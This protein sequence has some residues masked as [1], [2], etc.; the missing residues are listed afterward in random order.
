MK[1]FTKSILALA[2]LLL[3][4]VQ[5]SAIDVNGVDVNQPII[6]GVE[7]ISFDTNFMA[8][9][10]GFTLGTIVHCKLGDSN[11]DIG[12]LQGITALTV[13]GKKENMSIV[14]GDFNLTV[15]LPAGFKTGPLDFNCYVTDYNKN[16]GR[17]SV[18]TIQIQ[19]TITTTEFTV[20]DAAGGA[21]CSIPNYA[22]SRI[23]ILDT[24]NNSYILF[25]DTIDINRNYNLDGN[26]QFTEQDGSTD[27]SLEVD[28][29]QLAQFANKRAHI[30][31]KALSFPSTPDLYYIPDGST[32]KQVCPT[33]LCYN[34]TYE[35]GTLEFDAE[36]FSLFAASQTS[37]RNIKQTIFAQPAAAMSITD[38]LFYIGGIS[39]TKLHAI[40]VLIAVIGLAVGWYAVSKK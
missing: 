12:R 5:V 17:S 23:K 36:H 29:T 33:D 10:A 1:N 15:K 8:N 6:S 11:V 28:T 18:D 14:T 34:V 38:S 30:V 9:V 2:I 31:M 7:C 25:Y 24:T 19:P 32:V 16:D 22:A 40:V 3:I 26:I 27:P 4:S 21:W 13:P 35:N 37:G 39:I 20:T